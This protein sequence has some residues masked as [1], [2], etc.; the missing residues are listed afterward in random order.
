ML[1]SLDI[2]LLRLLFEDSNQARVL[3]PLYKQ[4]GRRARARSIGT[5]KLT[6]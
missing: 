2:E 5:I 4:Y 6:S 1:D 3:I